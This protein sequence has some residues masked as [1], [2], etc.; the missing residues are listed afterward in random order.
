MTNYLVKTGNAE[1]F[2]NA[3]RTAKAPE[4]FTTR[5]LKDLEFSSSNDR[6]Y[7]GV[8]KGLGFLDDNGVPQQ[9]YFNFLDQAQSA[10]VLAEAI[11]DAYADLFA[12][13]RAAQT[14][15]VEEVR[16]KFKTLTQGQKSDNV[17]NWMANTFYTLCG[18]ADW[19]RKPK[20][21][22]QPPPEE[23]KKP[24]E[25]PAAPLSSAPLQLHYN[26]QI[27]LPESRDQAVY[28]ALFSSLR[29]HLA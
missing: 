29:R 25:V 18:L 28:D 27:V 14:L 2:F 21:Q 20:D 4:R 16:G 10:A 7:I 13:N 24:P 11:E 3:L 5:F 26:I 8:L 19:S 9:R 12:I 1:E 22:K 23:D 15:E 6:L 17:I